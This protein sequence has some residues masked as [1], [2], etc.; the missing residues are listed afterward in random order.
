MIRRYGY[1]VL[2]DNY[3]NNFLINPQNKNSAFIKDTKFS[4]IVDLYYLDNKI[5]QLVFA[6]MQS[7]EIKLKNAMEI[8]ISQNISSNYIEFSKPQYFTSQKIYINSNHRQQRPVTRN[9]LR[10]TC[11]RNKVKKLKEQGIKVNLDNLIYSLY[12]HEIADWYFLLPEEIKRRV[13]EYLLVNEFKIVD[14]SSM[15]PTDMVDYTLRMFIGFRNQAAHE[16]PIF[17]YYD[18]HI[19]YPYKTIYSR[20]RNLMPKKSPY[21]CCIGTL[22]LGLYFLSNKTIFQN[23][24]DNIFKIISEYVI[25]HPDEFNIIKKMGLE[26]L[27]IIDGKF[28][29]LYISLIKRKLLKNKNE[30]KL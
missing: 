12:F 17:N 18:E 16:G 21:H 19:E 14:S 20:G 3:Q 13:I 27:Y 1:R 9:W 10:H 2:I 24:S 15:I 23:F 11:F 6:S 25:N 7:F 4:D 30:N 5:R 28:N 26:V 22:L 29:K 8:V